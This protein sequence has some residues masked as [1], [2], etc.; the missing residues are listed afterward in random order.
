MTDAVVS[1]S[2]AIIGTALGWVLSE[3][4]AGWRGY[5]ER[6]RADQAE[7]TARVFDAARTAVAISEGARWL[8]QVDV[9]KKLHG[10]GIGR[11]EYA[12]KA[13]EVAEQIQQLRL[14]PLSV[15]AK[16]PRSA[17]S[18]IDVLVAQTQAL[19]DDFVATTRADI[20]DHPGPFLSACDQ[21]AKN[22]RKLVGP[23]AP[24]GE[25]P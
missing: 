24:A 6:R 19:W 20:A 16:G 14:I 12:K 17:L 23:S 22:A 11:Q 21:I 18:R 2:F 8:I 4:G 15:T 7:A 10:E 25:I 3:V 1:G 5:A 13:I 9:A